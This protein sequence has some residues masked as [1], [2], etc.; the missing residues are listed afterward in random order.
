MASG[1]RLALFLLFG[2]WLLWLRQ[3][4]TLLAY[5]MRPT[6]RTLRVMETV[7][8]DQV[9]ER[10]AGAA[11]PVGVLGVHSAYL[12]WKGVGVWSLGYLGRGSSP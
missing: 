4:R 3:A 11:N 5:L 10:P 6:M 8:Y 2:I 12:C 1:Q 7:S 9:M